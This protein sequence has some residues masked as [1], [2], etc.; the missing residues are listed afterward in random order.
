MELS[1]VP[2]I[3]SSMCCCECVSAL[4]R[5]NEGVYR[6]RRSWSHA[7][8][9]KWAGRFLRTITELNK[10]LMDRAKKHFS[11]QFHVTTLEIRS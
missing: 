1:S 5:V 3:H 11:T 2:F 4:T 7:R 10:G 8:I 9:F 6:Q